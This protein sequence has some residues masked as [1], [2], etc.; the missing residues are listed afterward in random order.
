MASGPLPIRLLAMDVDGTLTDGRIELAGDG[1]ERKTFHARDG[2][3]IRLLPLA[4]ITP[5]IVSGRASALTARRAAELGIVH[6]HQAE[7][8]KARCLLA[9]C[10]ELGLE[11]AEAAF[12]GDDLSDI[13]AMSMAGWSA[14][15]ADAA[16]EARDVADYV[17]HAAGGH[18]AVREAI[19]ALLRREGHWEAVLA[20]FRSTS[21][22][23]TP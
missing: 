13:P 2:Q 3:G 15:P 12:M 10:A 11:P 21:T 8:D 18:G 1:Q 19:E 20:T 22:E 9:L 6:V 5:A 17:T 7:G 14:V 23:V 16:S 4:G